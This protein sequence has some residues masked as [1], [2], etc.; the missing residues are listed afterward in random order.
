M[1]PCVLHLPA[2]L[3]CC[4]KHYSKVGIQVKV[5]LGIKETNIIDLFNQVQLYPNTI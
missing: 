1:I 5:E 4:L 2:Y 3:G